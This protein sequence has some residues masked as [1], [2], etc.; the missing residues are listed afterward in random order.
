[1][2]ATRFSAMSQAGWKTPS[3][4]YPQFV[5]AL[6]GKVLREALFWLRPGAACIQAA[7][8]KRIR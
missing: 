8:D 7:N 4:V 2:V 6:G 3:L 5:S 1:M